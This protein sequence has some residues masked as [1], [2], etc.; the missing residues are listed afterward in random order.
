MGDCEYEGKTD[1][2][3]VAARGRGLAIGRL[4]VLIGVFVLVGVPIVAVLWDAVNHVVEGEL[5]RLVIALPALAV[6]VAFLF[7]LGNRIRR[8]E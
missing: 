1:G 8:L 7:V 3:I 6:F 4:M 5:G 2:W